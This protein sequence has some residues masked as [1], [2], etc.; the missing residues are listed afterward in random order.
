MC[1]PGPLLC[2][3]AALGQKGPRGPTLCLVLALHI[4]LFGSCH[5]CP[6]M[7]SCFTTTVSCR[8]AGLRTIPQ[9]LPANVEEL[10]VTGNNITYITNES[11]PVVLHHLTRLHL[12]ANSMMAVGPGSFANLPRLEVLDLSDNSL[13]AF[14]LGMFDI[15]QLSRL[16][17]RNNT[18]VDFGDAAL[19]SPK[20]RHLDLRDNAL[21]K[22][23]NA[24]MLAFAQRTDFSVLLAGNSWV[25]D[26]NIEDFVA[27]LRNSDAIHDKQNLSCISPENL[28][29]VGLLRVNRSELQCP[30]SG[31][32]ERALETSYVFLGMVLALIGLIFLLVLYLNRKG[33]K[34]WLY[35]IRDACRDHM[36]GY[37]YRY[38]INSDPRL[39][40]I[41]LNSDV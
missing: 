7:C 8:N 31:G 39:A 16:N 33:I 22:L 17:L 6:D 28:L 41:S 14:R 5:A 29:D 25:C 21:K 10:I 36:E 11:F 38:E 19:K 12:N 27:W 24:T 23:S 13:L 32:M 37:H 2:I 30:S 20:L 4:L 40:N 3:S 34:R 1:L 35:N 15:P 18:L 26:C 9:S